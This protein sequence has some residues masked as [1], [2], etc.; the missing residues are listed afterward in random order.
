MSKKILVSAV[1]CFVLGI[2]VA[3]I[4]RVPESNA[5][6][7][8]NAKM[9]FT[10]DDFDFGKITEGDIVEHVFRFT[11][12]GIDTLKI[13]DVKASCGC[14]AVLLSTNTIPP[15]GKGEIKATFNSRGKT[16]K[17]KKNI[18]IRINDA[19]GS[20]QVIYFTVFV[21]PRMGESS[22]PNH[23]GNMMGSYFEGQCVNCHVEP[24]LDKFGKELF[25]ASCAMCHGQEGKGG[26]AFALDS[27]A[28]LRKT[29]NAYLEKVIAEGSP[30]NKM[31][32]GFS[33]DHNGPL[34]NAQIQSLEKYIRG[35]EKNKF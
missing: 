35:W 30:K 15:G 10:E 11:N 14:T 27:A 17:I 3:W 18:R 7:T 4:Y 12:I 26:V 25:A 31:M 1:V 6:Q 32:L 16:G 13:I 19:Q 29:D 22:A 21:E 8:A 28:Y 20:A 2:C 23:P 5:L 9:K 33:M 24:G 34:D